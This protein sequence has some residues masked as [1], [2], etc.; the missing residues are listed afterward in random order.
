M[1]EF[2]FVKSSKEKIS[3]KYQIDKKIRIISKMKKA[4]YDFY[5]GWDIL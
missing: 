3:K 1:R 5:N 4:K 2:V